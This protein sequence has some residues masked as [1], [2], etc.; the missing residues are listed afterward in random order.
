VKIILPVA[1]A[2]MVLLEALNLKTSERAGLVYAVVFVFIVLGTGAYEAWSR[3]RGVPGWIVNILASAFGCFLAVGV[4]GFGME[5]AIARVQWA[6]APSI[7]NYVVAAV[8]TSFIVIVSWLPIKL[9][10]LFRPH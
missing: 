8:G 7:Q 5:A 9:I 2:A 3:K 6:M 1:V 4:L 10:D